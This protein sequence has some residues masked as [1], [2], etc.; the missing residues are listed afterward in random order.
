MENFSVFINAKSGSPLF[1]QSELSCHFINDMARRKTSR[2]KRGRKRVKKSCKS[3]FATAL[4]RLKKL[5]RH[6]RYRAMSIANDSFIRQFCSKVKKLKHAKVSPKTRK[7]L[8]KHKKKLRK[9]LGK[10][11]TVKQKRTMLSQRGGGIDWLD[12]LLTAIPVGLSMI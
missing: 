1:M 4:K 7:A 9:L 3:S 6:D 12:I 5:K 11:T 10:R 2:K 8:Q